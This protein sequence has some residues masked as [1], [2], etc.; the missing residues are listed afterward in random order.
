MT[1]GN[2]VYAYTD[3][4]ANNSPDAGSAPDGGSSLNFNFPLD[5]T[6][7]PSAYRPAAVTNLFYA[8]NF[9]HDVMYRYGFTEALDGAKA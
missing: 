6:Q 3:T 9:I 5:L 2:N 1:R 8:N 7:A 4:D